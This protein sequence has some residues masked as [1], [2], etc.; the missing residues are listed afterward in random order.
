MNILMIGSG[1]REHALVKKLLES[2][3][4][5]N[6][7]TAPGNGGISC[8][9]ICINIPVTDKAAMVEFAKGHNIDLAF[10]APDDPL[11][12]F[13]EPYEKIQYTHSRI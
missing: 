3:K 7:Y 8:D 5:E 1:G 4:L 9:S 2:P 13:K 12:L 11:G 10:V 6:L